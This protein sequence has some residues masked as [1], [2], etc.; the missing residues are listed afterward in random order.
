[1]VKYALNDYKGC[2]EDCNSALNLTQ[3]ADSYYMRGASRFLLQDYNGS[4]DDFNGA[5][6]IKPDYKLAVLE[7]GVTYFMLEKDD[8]A[9]NDLNTSIISNP[10]SSRAYYYRGLTKKY[11][12]DLN[13]SCADLKKAQSLGDKYA[14][15]D[16]IKNGCK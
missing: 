15:D 14:G 4:L 16:L 2:V 10:N 8:L 12:N 11:K 6:N 13:G 7:R 9:L 1:L 3:T 5:L